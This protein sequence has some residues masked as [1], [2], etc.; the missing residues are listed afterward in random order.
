MKNK[1]WL[2]LA[3]L[4]SGPTLLP[5]SLGIISLIELFGF[6]G[7][8]SMYASYAQYLVSHPHTQKALLVGTCWDVQPQIRL[9]FD[10]L[11]AYPQLLFHMFPIKSVLIW[12]VNIIFWSSCIKLYVI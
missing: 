8:W 9:S 11:K 7:L 4:V 1:K 5:F 10:N 12:T 2:F 6:L 3:L